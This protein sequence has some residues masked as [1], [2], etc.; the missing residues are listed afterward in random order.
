METPSFWWKLASTGLIAILGAGV[1]FMSAD[2]AR[3]PRRGLHLSIP[4][5]IA[6]GELIR[7]AAPT[8]PSG[9]ALAVGL[10]SAA[11][12]AFVSVFACSL[13]DPLYIVVCYAVGCSIVTVVGR[14]VF[15]R[16][17]RW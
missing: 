6:L 8:D 15:L 12:E 10:S 14:A 13:D 5:A 3:S 9:T 4:P 1:A 16:R 17:S 7:R 11:W 2:P